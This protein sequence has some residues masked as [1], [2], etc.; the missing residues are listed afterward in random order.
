[1]RRVKQVN[2]VGAAARQQSPDGIP[3]RETSVGKANNVRN[4]MEVYTS[5]DQFLGKVDRVMDNALSVGGQ[6]IEQSKIARVAGNRVYITGVYHELSGQTQQRA[7]DQGTM[8]VPVHEERLEVDKR[9][10]E[11]GEVAIRKTVETEDVVVP[12]ELRR[13]EVQVHE[14]DIDDRQVAAGAIDNAFQEQTIRVPVRG[15]EAIVEKQIYV[16]GEVEIDKTERVER[17]E[18][19]DTVRREH[20]DI[21]ENYQRLRPEFQRNYEQSAKTQGWK[22]S[23]EEREAPY[24]YGVEAGY[25]ERYSGRNFEDVEPM[26]RQ[27]FE[28]RY[29]GSDGWEQLREQVRHAYNRVRQ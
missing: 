5:D 19:R 11:L 21:D 24:R 9:S 14:R 25:D 12:V 7:G 15:E 20:V 10:G 17:Q 2:Q 29:R 4:G 27:D 16:T 18:V 8:R 26:L 22:Q 28:T 23:F 13:E 3:V 6:R 1:M